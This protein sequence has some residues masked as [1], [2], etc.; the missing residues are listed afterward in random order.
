MRNANL[1]IT[2]LI[3]LMSCSE[4]SSNQS[5][6]IQN[7]IKVDDEIISKVNNKTASQAENKNEEEK[8]IKGEFKINSSSLIFNRNLKVS[9]D[10][11]DNFIAVWLNE[12]DKDG[13]PYINFKKY[14]SNN[15]EV[16]NYEKINSSYFGLEPKIAKNNN[17]DFIIIWHDS[18][19]IY[20]QKFSNNSLAGKVYKLH[21]IS[22]N[23]SISNCSIDMNG[24]G[25]FII[26]WNEGIR[27]KLEN[28]NG[29]KTHTII[30]NYL[31]AKKF[32][33]TSTFE[34][35]EL[36]ISKYEKTI[37]LVEKSSIPPEEYANLNSSIVKINNKGEIII[38]YDR[39]IQAEKSL[40]RL[41]L[42]KYNSNF[43]LSIDELPL[44]D[45]YVPYSTNYG[46]SRIYGDI[47]MNENG[48]FIAVYSND[49]DI[50]AK[51]FDKNVKPIVNSFMVNTYTKG[52]QNDPSVGI[53]K[54]GN[55]FI[56]WS[57]QEQD[58]NGFG[59]FS[60]KFDMNNK[61][62][63]AENRVNTTTVKDQIVPALSVNSQGN[64]I[65]SWIS[66]V[67][68]KSSFDI[69]AQRYNF[70]GIAE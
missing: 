23:T 13:T 38:L 7:E 37:N 21:S 10:N 5:V 11:N 22:R 4:Q 68:G 42:K 64:I 32:N 39:V 48:D 70:D 58:G 3:F 47:S 33:F 66:G 2:V 19:N 8:L 9:L 31:Y 12:D 29:L 50:Y 44:F 28:K 60:Q 36:Q 25:D 46:F 57:S 16:N 63:G 35:E 18:K 51:R 20:A 56:A 62:V 65:I 1:L 40:H 14:N 34:S 55:S 45:G 49:D 43:D 27:E 52:I 59:I 53:D 69:Y 67:I 54:I 17:G 26:S 24:P 15:K 6:V 41:Y 61:P 30:K